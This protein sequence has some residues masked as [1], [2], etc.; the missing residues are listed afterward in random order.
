MH[1]L[2]NFYTPLSGVPQKCFKSAPALANA[3]PGNTISIGS[4]VEVN[5]LMKKL[6][7]FWQYDL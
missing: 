5:R 1:P 7:V 4:I 2:K 3:G 6:A